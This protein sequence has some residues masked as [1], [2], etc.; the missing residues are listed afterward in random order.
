MNAETIGPHPKDKSKIKFLL[1]VLTIVS[2]WYLGRNLRIDTQKIQDSLRDF[3][4]LYGGILYVALYVV[5]TFFVFF[6]KDF[7]WFMGAVVFGPYLSALFVW[8]A[9]TVNAFILFYL[10]RYLGRD[11]IEQH[12]T[13]RYKKIDEELGALNFSWL[14][15]F[16]AAPLIPYRFL[17]LG[18]GLTP[19]S[20][21][22]YLIAVI[23]GS[24]FKVFWIQYVLAGVGTSLF[25]NP[26]ALVE[27]FLKNKGLLA[28]S[29]IYPLLVI[30]VILKLKG[31]KK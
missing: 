16:R 8:I 20:F 24:P 27:Y 11:F 5:I 17:D 13:Q 10:A 9:E 23:F 19:I 4:L 30:L 2:L 21:N 26:A 29:L 25:N 12:L 31:R 3:P 6:S 7:F 28:F 14:F 22:R 15:I 1:L 18:A